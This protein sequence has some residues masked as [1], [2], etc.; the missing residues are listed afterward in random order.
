MS[1][2]QYPSQ[3]PGGY[4]GQPEQGYGYQGQPQQGYPNQ[5]P[6][7]NNGYQGQPQPGYGYQGQPQPGMGY[8]GQPPMG[9]APQ[10]GYGY[11]MGGAA[12]MPKASFGQRLG[13]YV[14]DG[15]IMTVIAWVLIFIGGI[16]GAAMGT[17]PGVDAYG[18]PT[19]NLSGGGVIV[20]LIF[21]LAAI[22]VPILYY[23]IL[24]GRGQTLGNRAVGM[25][26]IRADGSAPGA[27]RA[28]LRLI[29]QGIVGG[30]FFLSYLWMLWDPEQQTLHDKVAGTYGVAAR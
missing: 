13:A 26:I 15:V 19:N 18:N 7:P 10:S 27:G 3:Q 4:Q 16:I 17:T 8:P 11:P 29:I 9:Y 2:P 24:V 6:P 30:I 14:I 5:V 25:R 22:I 20:L 12:S 1:N 21:V 23:V 28:F